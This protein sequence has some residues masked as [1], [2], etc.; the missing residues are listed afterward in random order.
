M[1][2]A[3]IWNCKLNSSYFN[4][5]QNKIFWAQKKIDGYIDPPEDK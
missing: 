5:P 4:L 3:Q 1:A 2:H